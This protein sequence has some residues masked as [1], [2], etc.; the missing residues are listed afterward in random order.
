[1]NE[2][3]RCHPIVCFSFFAF[4]IGFSMFFMHPVC[5]AISLFF[6]LLYQAMLKGTAALFKKLLYILPAVIFTAALNPLFNHRGM[7]V[8]FYLPDKN[9][10]TAESLIYGVSAAVMLLSVIFWFSAYNA[11]M[12]SDKFLCVFGRVIPLLSL[13]ISMALRFTVR[14]SDEIKKVAAAKKCMGQGMKGKSIVK[15]IRYAL[16]ILSVMASWALE[17]SVETADSMRARGYASA[18]RTAYSA[19]RFGRFDLLVLLSV[20]V[21]GIYTLFGGVSGKMRFSYFPTVS[22]DGPFHISFFLSYA[23]LCAVPLIIEITEERK[24]KALRSKI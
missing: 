4:V 10:M 22:F 23:L 12:T 8:L 3:M 16:D 2:F 5:L 1:M 6:A 21:P 24:W 19:Y 9:P 17:N 14:F 15:K 20:L 11:V 13:V 7:T 18:K